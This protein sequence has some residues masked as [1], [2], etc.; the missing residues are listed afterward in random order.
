[1]F[2]SWQSPCAYGLAQLL[3]RGHVAGKSLAIGELI[4][5]IGAL[6]VEIVEEAGGTALVG[7]LADVAGLLGLVD[8]AAAIELD[9]LIVAVKGFVRINDIGENL[10]GGFA[11]EFLILCD[12][13]ASARDFALVAVEDGELNVEEE[14]AGVGSGHVRVVEAGAEVALAVGDGERFL[15]ASGDQ[16]LL[17]GAEVRAGAQGKGF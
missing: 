6:G 11:G 16:V 17:S 3:E 1:M 13:V 12:G 15:A 7:I 14:G 9:D 8:V 5:A 2:F 4:G 10:L